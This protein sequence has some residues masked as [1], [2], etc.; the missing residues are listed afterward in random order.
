MSVDLEYEIYCL[1]SE[2]VYYFSIYEL[3]NKI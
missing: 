3:L 2:I 1:V